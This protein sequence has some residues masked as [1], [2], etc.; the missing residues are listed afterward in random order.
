LKALTCLEANEA[1]P[2]DVYIF[3]HAV[4]WAMKETLVNP[5]LEYPT[6]VQEQV[7]GI[8][9]SRHNQIFGDGNLSTSKNLY[10]SGAYLNPCALQFLYFLI[11]CLREVG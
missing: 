10:L 9:N 11:L 7:L 2:G 8:L 6:D 5:L 3:W 1:N 4:M